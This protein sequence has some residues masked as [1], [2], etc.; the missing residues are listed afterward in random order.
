MPHAKNTLGLFGAPVGHVK[1]VK[2]Q[3]SQIVETNLRPSFQMQLD[4]GVLR[5]GDGESNSRSLTLPT[6]IAANCKRQNTIEL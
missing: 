5:I 4:A 3:I 1:G 2:V 6:A